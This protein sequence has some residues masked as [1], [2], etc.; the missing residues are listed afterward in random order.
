MAGIKKVSVTHDL[1]L[2]WLIANPGVNQSLCALEFGISE[3]WLSTVIHS[4]CFQELLHVRQD[5]L[6]GDVGLTV[7]DRIVN[8]A[9]E[10]LSRLTE[11]VQVEHDVSKLVPAAELAITALG[12]APDR[13]NGHNGHQVNNTLI[14]TGGTVDK[15]TLA[16]ARSFMAAKD[17]TPIPVPAALP[18]PSTPIVLN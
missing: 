9:H 11:R 17:I 10:S 1:I 12:F 15:E 7:K 4:D 8:L 3:A 6:F 14:I 2:D 5:Q 18:E 13:K 16:Q